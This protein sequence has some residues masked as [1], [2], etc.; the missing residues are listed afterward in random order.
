MSRVEVYRHINGVKL[1]KWLAVNPDVQAAMHVHS[2]AIYAE[3]KARHAAYV[4]S[5]STMKSHAGGDTGSYVEYEHTRGVDDYII[6]S[7]EKSQMAAGIVAAI[8]DLFSPYAKVR[9]GSIRR[10]RR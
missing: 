1:E 8:T 4:R 3:V 9:T 6:L 2:A 10:K 7:D 5:A